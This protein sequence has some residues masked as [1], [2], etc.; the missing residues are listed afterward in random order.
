MK[1][2]IELKVILPDNFPGQMLR[3]IHIFDAWPQFPDEAA[4]MQATLGSAAG[5]V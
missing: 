5:T 2:E 4:A 1:T 3:R